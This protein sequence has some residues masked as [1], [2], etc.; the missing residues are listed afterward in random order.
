[1]GGIGGFDPVGAISN[2]LGRAADNYDDT[3]KGAALGYGALGGAGGA[4]LGATAG[5]SKDQYDQ[6]YADAKAR[7][8]AMRRAEAERQA[9]IQAA[10]TKINQTFGAYD[11]GYY[12]QIQDDYLASAMPQLD[13]QYNQAR[14]QLV[15]SLKGNGPGI[16]SSYGARQMAGLKKQ[17][18]GQQAGVRDKALSYADQVRANLQKARQGLTDQARGGSGIENIGEMAARE[19]ENAA[20]PPAYDPLADVFAAYTGTVANNAAAQRAGYR[21]ADTPLVFSNSGGSSSKGSATTVK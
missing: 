2:E 20:T 19:A 13:D 16:A 10:L 12:G 14:R 15:L 17:Y 21:G 3:M 6:Q 7:A 5:Y 1:M 9:K 18:Y 4:E 8:E 11:D